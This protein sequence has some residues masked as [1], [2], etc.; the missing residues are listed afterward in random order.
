MLDLHLPCVYVQSYRR[1]DWERLLIIILTGIPCI[2]H[3]CADIDHFCT[4]CNRRVAHIPNGGQVQVL[5]DQGPHT[6]PSSYAAGPDIE[7]N[8]GVNTVKVA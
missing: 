4:N 5:S 8:A 7:A 3:W 1:I 2:A 6:V